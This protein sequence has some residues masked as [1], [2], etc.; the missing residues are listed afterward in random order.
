[1]AERRVSANG[2]W[3]ERDGSIVTVGLTRRAVDQLGTVV[4]VHLPEVTET[5][6]RGDVAVVVESS[7][8]AI[9]CESPMSGTVKAVNFQLLSSPDLLNE[10][11]EHDGWL[12]RLEHVDDHEW[13]KLPLPSSPQSSPAAQSSDV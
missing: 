11:P 8:A 12:Y 5:I 13:D 7:K 10:A 3:L 1:M 2:E 4:S 9:D 6:H